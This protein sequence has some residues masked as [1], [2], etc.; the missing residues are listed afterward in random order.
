[1]D[2]TAAPTGHDLKVERV[3]ARVKQYELALKMGVSGTRISAIEREQFP[4]PEIV[5]RYRVALA[6][7]QHV[8]HT[9]EVA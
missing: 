1:M 9:A 6:E 2:T 3:S 4:S 8:P 5:R 7:C